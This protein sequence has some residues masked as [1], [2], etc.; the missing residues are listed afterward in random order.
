[1]K[2]ISSI[3]LTLCLLL[4]TAIGVQAQNASDA[5]VTAY[6]TAYD[7]AV[8]VRD[9]LTAIESDLENLKAAG[10]TDYGKF[11]AAKIV[12]LQKIGVDYERNTYSTASGQSAV[13]SATAELQSVNNLTHEYYVGNDVTTLTHTWYR[14]KMVSTGKYL[15]Y[16][17]AN[18]F[19]DDVSGENQIWYLTKPTNVNGRFGLYVYNYLKENDKKG[20]TGGGAF[21]GLAPSGTVNGQTAYTIKSGGSGNPTIREINAN[22][23]ISYGAFNDYRDLRYRVVLEEIT[24][25][26]TVETE[27]TDGD[28]DLAFNGASAGVVTV[29]DNKVVIADKSY[30]ITRYGS[31]TSYTYAIGSSDDNGYLINAARNIETGANAIPRPGFTLTP[32][33]TATTEAD[34]T[35][36]QT[37][38]SAATLMRNALIAIE[39]NLE[40]LKASGTTD[41]GKFEAA[42]I[43]ILQKIGADYQSGTYTTASVRTEVLAATD[44]LNSVSD[45]LNKYYVGGDYTGITHTWYRL[46]MAATGK[47]LT[48][49]TENK[50]ADNNASGENQIWYLTETTTTN[51]GRYALYVYSGLKEGTKQVMNGANN[52]FFNLC[53]AGVVNG[54]TVYTLKSGGSGNPTIRDINVDGTI[55]YGAFD[56]YRDLK[57]RV[58]LEEVTNLYVPETELDNGEYDLSFN[59]SNAVTVTVTDN[60]VVSSNKTY[61]ITRY[62][63]AAPYTYAIGSND[64]NGYLISENLDTDADVPGVNSVP[65]PGFTLTKQTG[66]NST[67][68]TVDNDPVVSVR[69]FNLQG[70]EVFDISNMTGVFIVQKVYQSSKVET[71]KTVVNNK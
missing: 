23:T 1:M 49:D 28:Y 46:K 66:T 29:A 36:Y 57:Y 41:Y 55:S 16:D 60:K 71:T 32:A 31:V 2:Q 25:L 15:T 59:G 65:R 67:E 61:A 43:S 56:D 10:T 62:G 51:I 35:A 9:A 44:E 47:Y 40:N 37:A 24:D 42:K 54:Q 21:F 70:T 50:F 4:T 11:D 53:P 30:V 52:N 7:A 17:A 48:Y 33:A 8:V 68:Y 5:D 6:Q 27:L 45:L 64:D 14:M 34:I 58:V 69:Y 20:M 13:Q 3:F 22:G 63:N 26:F 12:I 19:L 18:K 38:L 39:S